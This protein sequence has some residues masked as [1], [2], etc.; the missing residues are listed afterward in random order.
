VSRQEPFA[1]HRFSVE[2]EGIEASGALSVVLPEARIV[3]A[4]ASAPRLECGSLVVTRGQTSSSDWYAWWDEARR[5]APGPG[6]SV[7]VVLLDGA[8]NEALRWKYT[9]ARPVAYR[10]SPLHALESGLLA[11]TL[12]IAVRSFDAVFAPPRTTT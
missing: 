2:V 11:E 6:R 3:A 12:E 1:S 10:V 7:A 9:G 8:G 4:D 5:S